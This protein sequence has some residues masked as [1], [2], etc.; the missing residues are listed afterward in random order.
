MAKNIVILHGWQQDLECWF[1]LKN[2]LVKKYKV[3]FP[4]FP[5]LGKTKLDH[6]FTLDDYVIWLEDYL[7]ENNISKPYFLAFSFG[8]RVAIAYAA[9]QKPLS[10]L[11]LVAAAG[12]KP[13]ENWKKTIGMLL[14]KTGKLFLS[15]P[16]LSLLQKPASWLLYTL[17][18]EKD[19]YRANKVLKKTMTNVLGVDLT[20]HLEKIKVPTLILWGGED[21]ITP[22]EDAYLMNKKVV[23]SQLK[24]FKEE[25]HNLP[26]RKPKEL[27]QTI[28]KFVRENA[29]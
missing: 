28:T 5:G 16:P 4:I 15:I 23:H 9:K 13:K 10:G 29:I 26:L 27:A 21:R 24:I 2:I 18:R 1:E 14:A 25:G 8:G 19:Y 3:Y 22:I 7:K 20:N 6:P 17:L 11:I 12:I